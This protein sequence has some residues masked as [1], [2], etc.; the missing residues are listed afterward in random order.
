MEKRGKKG[1]GEKKERQGN[2]TSP[3]ASLSPREVCFSRTRFPWVLA[4]QRGVRLGSHSPRNCHQ[5]QCHRAGLPAERAAGGLPGLLPPS[6]PPDPPGLPRSAPLRGSDRR[7]PPPRPRGSPRR[8]PRSCPRRSAGTGAAEPG[9]GAGRPGGT[10]PYIASLSRFRASLTAEPML[11][12]MT[13]GCG[14]WAP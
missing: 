14:A 2:N 3:Q 1:G 5:W 8:P 6:L 9:H 4:P 11:A 13:L 10:Y 12:G 7:R